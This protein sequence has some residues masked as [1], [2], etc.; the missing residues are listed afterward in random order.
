MQGGYFSQGRFISRFQEDRE[1]SQSTLFAQSVSQVTL[2]QNNQYAKM[3]YFGATCLEPIRTGGEIISH[4][5]DLNS[6]H[7]SGLS[8][9]KN[10]EQR[11][12][13]RN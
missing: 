6:H 9:R 10:K 11:K 3:A 1:E 4:P 8:G 2:I 7:H 13:R 5:L 12:M